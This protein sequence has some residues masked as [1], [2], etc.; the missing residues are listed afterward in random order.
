MKFIIRPAVAEDCARI[1]PMQA[2]IAALHHEGRPDLFRTEA[3]FFTQE[4]FDQRLGDPAHTVLIAQTADGQVV[5]YAFAWVVAHRGHS[6]YVD[7]DTFYI[8]DI[9]VLSGFRRRGIATALF[10]ECKRRAA[11]LGCRNMELGVW[12]FNRDAIAFYEHCGMLP[13][14]LRMELTIDKEERT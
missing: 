4:A 5:G 6:T 10:S 11:E 9:C 13:R 3:R 7:F 1:R 12:T 2:E 8:D 14:T